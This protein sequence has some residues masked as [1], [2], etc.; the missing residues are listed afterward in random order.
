MFFRKKPSRVFVIQSDHLL[1][2]VSN[3]REREDLEY[4]IGNEPFGEHLSNRS[5]MGSAIPAKRRRFAVAMLGFTLLLFLG[6]SVELQLFEGNHYRALAQANRYRVTRV[7]P[8]R[9]LIYDREGAI[10]AQNIPSF[11]LT[12]TIADLPRTLSERRKEFA[13]ISDLAGLQPTDLDLLLTS[14]AS[15]PYDA[16]PV[17]RNIPFERAMHLSIETKHLPGFALEAGTL[18][19]YPSNISSLS[20]ILGYIGKISPDELENL[21]GQGYRPIDTIGKIGVEQTAE[22]TLRG[23]PGEMVA[24]VDAQ[25]R[26]TSVVSKTDPV[27]GI[28]IHLTI[29]APF[30]QFIEQ[31]LQDVFHRTQT[32]R[33]SVV[34]LNPKTGEIFALVSLPAFDNNAFSAGIDEESLNA[35]IQDKNQPLFFRAIA[36]GFPSGSI[37]K[38]FV[39]YAA[40]AEQVVTKHTSFLSTGGLRINDWFFPD[41]KAGGHGVTDIYKAISESVNTYFYIVG[42][43]FDQFNGL[44]VKRITDYASLFGFGKPTGVDLPGEAS[45]FL[46]SKEWK[47]QTKDERWYVGDTYHLAIG[48]GDFLTTPLQMARATGIIANKGVVVTPHVV[49][50]V[51]FVGEPIPNLDPSA[52]NIVRQAM[53]LTVTQGS[54]RALSSLPFSVAGK[55]GTAQA[56]GSERF[57][58]WFTGFAPFDDPEIVVAVLVEE[59]GESTA[60][61]VPI[62]RNILS[63]W[64]SRSDDLLRSLQ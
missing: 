34:A 23:T 33:G 40:L 48:Q 25:G 58:S 61:A 52:L 39:A 15:S 54:G 59:G 2:K 55:T 35:L 62:A 47:E 31:Q 19:S 11:V 36:G 22:Q 53:R 49:K 38:P 51:Q 3:E 20:H 9:G 7:L 4:A 13:I 41:W 32:S 42:G 21:K 14:Y 28:D 8:Q 6:R 12:M 50:G 26:E 24:E 43:G 16:I 63:W 18:R 30:Q 45:G 10:L 17:K 5:Q 60:A 64:M 1:G 27:A 56:P 57:H 29:D 44:G 46:P 37:F